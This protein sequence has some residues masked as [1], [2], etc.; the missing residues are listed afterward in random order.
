MTRHFL[1][2]ASDSWG[3]KIES[4]RNNNLAAEGAITF[5]PKSFVIKQFSEYFQKLRPWNNLRNPWFEEFWQDEFKCRIENPI[6]KPNRHVSYTKICNG[7]ETLSFT[8]DGFIHFVIDSVYSIAHA[9]QDLISTHCSNLNFNELIKCQHKIVFKGP[10][11]LK[12]I[13]NVNFKSITGR[14]VE[15]LKDKENSGDGL[16]PFEVFQ[17]QQDRNGIFGYKKITEWEKNKPFVLDKS[18]LKWNREDDK[19]PLSVCKEECGI[20]EVKQG[21]H[22][23]WV[24]VKC[25]EN[26]YVDMNNCIKCPQGFGP[27][28]NKTSCIKLVIE[29]MTFN[30]PFT[31]IPIIFSALGIVLTLY[32]IYIFIR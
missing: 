24:C 17:Y 20:G 27:N 3:T 14:Q 15:F 5:S 8:Q 12:A 16:A 21:D 2:I 26:Q 29:Y 19:I 23:C 13:R 18:M 1:W 6:F 25:E 28:E 9:I 31:L 22:C 10:E 32:V 11:F 30:S 4:I 7:H